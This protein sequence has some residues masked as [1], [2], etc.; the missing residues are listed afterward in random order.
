MKIMGVSIGG[1]TKKGGGFLW[2]ATK[3]QK[4][5][6]TEGAKKFSTSGADRPSLGK[7]FSPIPGC[8]L[9]DGWLHRA[10]TQK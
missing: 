10:A 5:K 7:L 8:V 2:I 3:E 6:R 4:M 9:V 1:I